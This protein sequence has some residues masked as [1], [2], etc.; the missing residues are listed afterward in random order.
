MFLG[1]TFPKLNLSL[2]KLKYRSSSY[3]L[4]SLHVDQMSVSAGLNAK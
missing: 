2:T 1:I 3:P 4:N